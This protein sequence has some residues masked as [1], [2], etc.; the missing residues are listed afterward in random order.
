MKKQVI[1]AIM[2]LIVSFIMVSCGD[3]MNYENCLNNVKKEFPT[4]VIYQAYGDSKFTFTVIDTSN[5][6]IYYV[7]TLS[8]VNSEITAIYPLR[9]VSN[10]P[11]LK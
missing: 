3:S 9:K 1:R 8:L 10:S 4:G 5:N 2:I 11:N 6:T 7:E